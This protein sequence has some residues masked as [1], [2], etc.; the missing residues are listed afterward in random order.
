M[1]EQIGEK[2]I[3]NG[4][5]TSM[6]S[7]PP[8]PENNSRFIDLSHE[9]TSRFLKEYGG[10]IGALSDEQYDEELE[11]DPTFGALNSTACSR[12][13]IGT[14]EI[15]DGQFYFLGILGRYQLDGEKPLLADWF[16]GVLCVPRGKK[17][18]T[19]SM[20]HTVREEEVHVQI[21]RGVV[22]QTEVVS[23]S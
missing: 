8:L 9:E 14:W 2:L 21:E 16:S 23:N 15:K 3:F 4:S 6:A 11:K 13:Y 7:L 5:V 18:K 1:T 19:S 22:I 12:C 10:R 20:F 17:L